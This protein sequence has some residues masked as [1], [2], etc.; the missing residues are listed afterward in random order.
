VK[1]VLL[2]CYD[3]HPLKGGESAVA[4]NT[5]MAISTAYQVTVVTRPNNIPDCLN[6]LASSD[7]KNVSFIG[8]DLPKF[9]VYI[10]RKFPMSVFAYCVLW[11]Y[12]LPIKHKYLKDSF[13]VVHSV[14]FVSDTIPVF[15]YKFNAISIWGPI[16]HHEPLPVFLSTRLE[17]LSSLISLFVRYVVWITFNFKKRNKKFD[18]IL[19]SNLSVT[20]R[21]GLHEN[22]H[23]FSS[24]GVSRS[25]TYRSP[26]IASD[27]NLLYVA[28]FVPVKGWN[29]VYECIKFISQSN[30]DLEVNFNLV[31]EGPQ[32]R[33]FKSRVEGLS[34][35]KNIR[36]MF[37]G[38]L[39][40]PNVLNMYKEAD[41]YICPSFE[42]G[43]V[44][45]AEA[46]SYSLPVVCFNNY[47]P[48]ETVGHGYPSRVDYNYNEFDCYHSFS[49]EV[50]RLVKDFEYRSHVSRLSFDVFATRLSWVVKTKDLLSIYKKFLR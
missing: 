20:N 7:I 23:Y 9:L 12:F 41:V 47:G 38:K 40:Y 33:E 34:I 24:T 25:A 2:I 49:L 31:G 15:I 26:R 43:G 17:R 45:V 4:W 5:M 16:S 39:S 32:L 35:P 27:I 44:A 3:I 21:L 1:K 18:A 13:D 30:L 22:G 19:Y 14:N 28:R 46:L 37:H 11:Q 42:G 6:Y 50:L 36:I 10:K 8:Y 48:G 29:V